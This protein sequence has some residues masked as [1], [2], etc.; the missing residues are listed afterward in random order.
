MKITAQTKEV[1]K[2][3]SYVIEEVPEVGTVIYTDYYNE[4]D[5]IVD[6][7]LRTEDGYDIDVPSLMEVVQDFIGE[8][9]ME[10]A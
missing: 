4:N 10:I 3:I 7:V 8:S 6:S 9:T 2:V 1:L 5:R